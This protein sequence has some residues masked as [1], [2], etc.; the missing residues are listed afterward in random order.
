MT[1]FETH[2]KILKTARRLFVQQGYT[3]TSM[4]Q[5]AEEAGIGKA[6]IYHHFPDKE[7]IILALVEENSV[8]VKELL[9]LVRAENDPRRRIRVATTSSVNF[10][11]E[12]ADIMRI[13]RTEIPG[14]R[15]KMKS[16]YLTFFDQYMAL[17]TDAIRNGIEQRIFRPVDPETTARVLMTMIQGTFAMTYLGAGRPQNPAE[18]AAALLDIFFQ[19]IDAR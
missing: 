2:D 5:V 19:G 6:T 17:L 4:R 3:A 11:Y 13:A 10:L 16:G 1:T 18:S 9:Q 7:A 15:N 8:A 14:W 12:F